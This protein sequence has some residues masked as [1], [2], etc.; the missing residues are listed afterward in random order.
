[1]VLLHRNNKD[2]SCRYRS[3]RHS[4]PQSVRQLT[5]NPQEVQFGTHRILIAQRMA[6][7]C[8]LAMAL[9]AVCSAVTSFTIRLEKG[10]PFRN[11]SIPQLTVTARR[12]NPGNGRVSPGLLRAFHSLDLLQHPPHCGRDAI[13]HPALHFNEFPGVRS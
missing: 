5:G 10:H 7:R 4:A 9:L 6:V 13:E 3:E 1:M 8:L 2:V 12:I 11:R